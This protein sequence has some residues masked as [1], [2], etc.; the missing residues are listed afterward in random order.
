MKLL[1]ILLI[2]SFLIIVLPKK[3][4]FTN[5]IGI[6]LTKKNEYGYKNPVL[7]GT[8]KCMTLQEIQNK[9]QEQKQ[10]K[11]RDKKKEKTKKPKW[12]LNDALNELKNKIFGQSQITTK[13]V[14]NMSNESNDFNELCS[15][16]AWDM[17]L[18]DNYGYKSI[19]SLGCPPNQKKAICSNK[20]RNGENIYGNYSFISSCLPENSN[21]VQVCKNKNQ[22][23]SKVDSFD[24]APYQKRVLCSSN[25]PTGNPSFHIIDEDPYSNVCGDEC[26]ALLSKN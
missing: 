7:Y 6:C 17:G 1:F 15:Q 5:N 14:S 4:R 18:K 20:Y 16:T 26:R 22:Y 25:P 10:K 24:C 8:D 2:L 13:C 3:E 11:K 9:E 19:T 21:F 23:V 12:N